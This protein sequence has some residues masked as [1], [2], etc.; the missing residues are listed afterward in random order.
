MKYFWLIASITALSSACDQTTSSEPV[1]RRTSAS[2]DYASNVQGD[3]EQIKGEIKDSIFRK[4]INSSNIPKAELHLAPVNTSPGA[5]YMD[6]AGLEVVSNAS[7]GSGLNLTAAEQRIVGSVDIRNSVP[8]RM[9]SSTQAYVQLLRQKF[10]PKCATFVQGELALLD[11]NSPTP[12]KLV[13]TR[14]KLSAEKISQFMSTVFRAAPNPGTLHT[15]A[16]EY[17]KSFSDILAANAS[18]SAQSIYAVMCLSIVTDPRT[19]L[20]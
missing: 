10:Y 18:E 6:A 20:R 12:R 2:I 19:Y 3:A 13:D 5:Y 8:S 9:R 11:A 4:R 1:S 7:F 17:A 14:T 16:T 15:G